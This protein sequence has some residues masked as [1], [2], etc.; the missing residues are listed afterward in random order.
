MNETPTLVLAFIAGVGLGAAFFG[1]L[2]WTPE[3]AMPSPRPAL[4]FAS[5]IL[6]RMGV[7]LTGFYFVSS[8]HWPRMLSCLLG[9]ALSRPVVTWL[10]RP[11][12]RP[13]AEAN[14]A[15]HP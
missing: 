9:F 13:L 3:K 5:S 11:P 14:H 8:G 2:W 7:T 15:A 10:T 1:S 12:A 6:L 4:W